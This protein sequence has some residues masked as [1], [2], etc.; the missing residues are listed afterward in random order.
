MEDAC[1]KLPWLKNNPKVE[2]V[3]FL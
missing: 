2:V 1:K 3:K